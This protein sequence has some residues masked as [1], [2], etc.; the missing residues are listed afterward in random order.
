MAQLLTGSSEPVVFNRDQQMSKSGIQSNRGDGY[1]TLVAFEWALT[2]LSDPDYQWLEVDSVTWQVDDVVIGKT[3]GTK[4]CCQCKKNQTAYRAWSISDLADELRKAS[5]LLASDPQTVVRFYSR[6]DF[7][8]LAALR[9][10]STS[11]AD[12]SAYCVNLGQAHGNTNASLKCLLLK[13]A[14]TLSSYEFLCRTT[15]ETSPELDRMETLLHE[16]LRQLASNPS[17][18]YDA[19]W[20]RLDQLGMRVNGNGHSSATQHRLTKEDLKALLAQAGAML[21]PSMNMV[22]V[23]ASFQNTSAIGR[24]WRRDIGNERL[25]NPVVNELLA[26]IEAKHRSIL[27]TGLP[28][29][30]KTCVMLALQEEL[31]KL[32][33][34]RSD[35]LPLFIQSREF[36]DFA[37]AQDR[38]AQGLSEQWVEKAAR[39]AEDSQVVVVID[40]LDVLSIAREHSVLTYFLAQI[41]RLLLIPN[42]TVITACRDFDR[43][44]DRRIAQRKW[45]KEFTCQPLD[46]DTEIA[47]LLVKLGVD[48][49]AMDPAT[50]D[51]ICNPRELALYVELA[52]Q[53]GSFNVVTSQALAQ[54]YLATV[55]QSNSALGDAA[56]QA[57]EAMA[58]E[59]LRLRSLTVP[60]QRFSASQDALRKLLSHHVLIEMQDGLLTF[61]HQTLLDVLVVSG[62]V[63]QGVSLNVFI[64][65]LSP[66]PFVRPSIRSF[67]AQ[68]ATGDRR[69]FRKQLRTVLTGKHAF[70]IRRLVA[71]SFADQIPQ[72]D[73]WPLIRDLRATHRDVFQVIYTQPTRV[74]WHYF[75]FKHLVPVLKDTRDVDGLTTH[76]HRVSQWRHDDAAGVISFWVE[77]LTMEGVDKTQFVHSMAHAITQIQAN[78]LA[79]LEP[80]LLILL[81]LPKQKHSFLGHALAHCMKVGNLDDSV[82]WNYV[83]G[84]VSDA[85]VLEYHF[86][87]KLH[88]QP[89][90]FGSSQDKFLADRMQKSTALLDMAI[91]SIEQWS[92]IKRSRY[93]DIPVSYWSG[94]LRETSY[95]NTHSQTD[96]RHVDGERI[97]LDA[98][99][100]AVVRHANTQSD[101][102]QNN[103]ERLCSNAE[104]ALRYFAI[105][106]CTAT[107]ASNLDVIERMLCD[108]PLLE[109][110]L[111]YEM[112]TLMQ[113]T[114]AQLDPAI[115]D[116]IQA[117]IPDL[118]QED[119]EDPQY[120]PWMLK[121][122]AQLILT[123]PCHL[124]SSAIQMVLDECEK[125]FWPLGRQPDIGMRGGMVSAPFSF[126]V[127]LVA[128][129]DAVL[130]LLAHYNGYDRNSFDDF[131]VGGEREVGMQLNEA[132]SRHPTRFLKLL[133]T[134]W[135]QISN[136]FRNDI[137]DGVAASLAHRHGNLQT[138]G[139]WSPIEGPDAASLAQK[140]LDELERHP[141]HWQHNRAASRALQACAHVVKSTSDAER[142]VFGAIGFLTLREESS[143]SGDSVDLL[144][145]GINMARGEVVEALLIVATRLQESGITWPELL[146]PVLRQFAADEHPAIRALILRRLPDLQS[147]QP[148]LGWALFD[149]AMQERAVGLWAMAE[150]CL[151]YASHQNFEK[152]APWLACIYCESSGKDLETWGRISALSALTIQLDFFALLGELKTLNVAEAWRG[153]AS[154]WTHAGNVQQHREQCLAGLDAG[155]NVE[156]QHALA[157]ARKYRNLFQETNP[158]VFTPIELLRRCFSL[159]GTEA[160]ESAR[161]D[162]YG[163]DAWLNASSIRDPMYALEATEIYLDF[164]RR[165]KPYVYDHENNLTQL[166]TRLFAQAEEQEESDSGAMLQRVVVV[167][168]ALLALGV[169]GVN[170]WLKVAERP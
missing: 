160:T 133:P 154:V 95:N 81:K 19:L 102:W 66:V 55:V 129:D 169:N 138:N 116:A 72:D 132:A 8:E 20:T 162:V 111:S 84:E 64:Q 142:L 40:S 131:L 10:Y 32:A 15:F 166:L 41:D 98:V 161:S 2:V 100:A 168:D 122:Q 80:L 104:G 5:S 97:L 34:T 113:N 42:V 22:E 164:V 124:R 92:Q 130:R 56:M 6:S 167:Q 135:A 35:L 48:A 115:Q 93:G 65:N 46:W 58:T 103:R 43:H 51:L 101:W 77:V 107:P 24:T 44:Y 170:D 155:L 88:C 94:F 156:N 60:K 37:T 149:L 83:A 63:R 12:E 47:P 159:L 136:R 106:A 110:D 54:R 70:H 105:L 26:A 27:L 61:G 127:F 153:A 59:M 158:L 90:E 120:R 144:T 165:T 79:L 1:Q 9:E 109:S 30:G 76:V 137:M 28:G 134:H 118:H 123:I 50:R 11:Y 17:A 126:D 23:R 87:K 45:S 112:G 7:G 86:G 29:A 52:Q 119:A 36:A 13:Q 128:S 89:H 147:L 145:I 38:Q 99:E 108:K 49:S 3:D 96:L 75:W 57:I 16:R 71:E 25:S 14:P 139:N 73:D 21:I 146:T 85:D 125:S 140:I 78:H 121:K 117:I 141:A 163:F 62:A 143:I 18:A 53:G 148:D 69:E 151:Y 152:V 91:A 67:I 68:L 4:I 39:M 157:V 33:Q 31:E 114:F 150:P 82:L 74:E